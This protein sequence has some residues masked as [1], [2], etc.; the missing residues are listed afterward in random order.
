MHT[1]Y[2]QVN[3]A[4]VALCVAFRIASVVGLVALLRHR[5]DD[6]TRH[7]CVAAI[8]NVRAAQNDLLGIAFGW[9]M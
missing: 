8:M 1:I 7:A 4:V 6:R 9:Y 3:T 5:C 2:I